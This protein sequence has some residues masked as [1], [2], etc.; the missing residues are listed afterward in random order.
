MTHTLTTDSKEPASQ[1]T[2]I[3]RQAGSANASSAVD[4]DLHGLVGIR[5]LGA[6]PADVAAVARQLGPVQASLNR[7]PDLVIRFVDQL[8]IT[9][10][11]RYLG[12]HDAAFTD[13]MFLVLRGKHKALVRVAIPFDRIGQ[14]G[15]EILCERGVPAVPLLIPIVNILALAN[16]ALPLHASAFLHRQTG[17]LVTGWAKGGKTE[18]LLAFMQVGGK[19]IGDEWVYLDESGTRMYG[20]PEPIKVWDWHLA[21][22]RHY[23]QK[24]GRTDRVRLRTLGWGVRWADRLTTLDGARKLAPVRL[25]RRVLPFAERQRYTH[26]PPHKLFGPEN[27][28]LKGPLDKVFFVVSHGAPTIEVEPIDPREVARRMVFSLQEERFTF[29]S[30]YN[31][32]LF[33]FPEARNPLIDNLETLQ[34]ER[35]ER[36]LADK[37]TYVVYHPYPVS[38]VELCRTVEAYI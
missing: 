30:Y 28:I 12:L 19:Y 33:A 16:G 18:T 1:P 37:P 26:M 34:R 13:T 22:L 23:W 32:F 36:I 15:C 24:V 31:K 4:F 27:V 14:K 25:V 5:L 21:D 7:E 11:V 35:L 17:V 10:R 3:S 38:L 8:P 9:S 6:T 2:S 29:L 20:V